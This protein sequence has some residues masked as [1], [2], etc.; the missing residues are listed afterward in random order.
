VDLTL[1]SAVYFAREVLPRM[2]KHKWG[3][4]VTITS[5]SVKQ[6]MDNMM[7]SNSIRSAVTAMAK[8]LSNE[9]GAYGITVNNVCPG[10]TRTDRL[11]E[12]A[13]TRA[14]AAGESRDKI[15]ERWAAQIPLGRV[16]RPEEFAAVVAFLVSERAS[17]V[18]GVSIAVDGGAVRSAV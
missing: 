9:F 13:D 4:L 12:L 2:Q 1:L 5:N 14:A 7:L 15:I 3:R 18:T 11:E 8:T 16:G 6:P 17:Y 10:F